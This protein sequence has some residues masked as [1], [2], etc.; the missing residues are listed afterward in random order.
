M[1]R[2]RERK[3]GGHPEGP[4]PA[5]ALTWLAS[6]ANLGLDDDQP[7]PP[8]VRL[9]QGGSGS[10]FL[11]AHGTERGYWFDPRR[12]FE[13]QKGVGPRGW[14]VVTQEW[15]GVVKRW[16]RPPGAPEDCLMP[17]PPDA[18]GVTFE[19][20]EKFLAASPPRPE[21]GAAADVVHWLPMSEQEKGP[22]RFADAQQ[23]ERVLVGLS[24]VRD[25]VRVYLEALYSLNE[26]PSPSPFWRWTVRS[27][28]ESVLVHCTGTDP[29]PMWM[30]KIPPRDRV[31]LVPLVNW[32]DADVHEYRARVGRRTDPGLQPMWTGEAWP[33]VVWAELLNTH[34]APS[35]WPLLR[36]CGWC[37]RFFLVEPGRVGR[38]PEF[39]CDACA[40]KFSARGPLDQT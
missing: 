21:M 16:M 37:Q 20:V 31:V 38:P 30:V 34:D 26:I 11:G 7:R 39:C 14:D 19:A 12:P 35:A 18:P 28:A 8:I 17:F 3:T 13:M 2:K 4:V 36:C 15:R 5:G 9:M 25:V 24:R 1:K 23:A 32:T 33:A 29:D 40:L 10:R 6:F 22:A 27:L